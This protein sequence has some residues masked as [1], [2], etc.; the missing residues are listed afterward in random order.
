MMDPQP[1]AWESDSLSKYFRDA[2]YNERVTALKY[3]T[4]YSLLRSVQEAFEWA[5]QAAA[6]GSGRATT[7]PRILLARAHS[8]FLAAVRLTMSGQATEAQIVLRSG[9]EQAWYALHIATDPAPSTRAEIWLRRHES[10][11]AT[12]R[13]RQ[14]FTVAKVRASHEGIDA[15]AA[16]AMHWLY[17]TLIDFGGH[18]NQ[19]GVLAAVERYED[20][21]RIDYKVAIL[22][23]DELRVM[24]ALRLAVAVAVGALRVFRHMYPERFAI[25]GLDDAI[26]YLERGLDTLFKQYARPV[27]RSAR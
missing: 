21:T 9:V 23:P 27:E 3:P 22:Q 20:E 15:E 7:L 11:E 1:P 25:V 18:P 17:E 8:A 12:A 13:C 6:K 14:E 2:E 4:V 16:A 26:G 5:E 19:R 10:E 24:I